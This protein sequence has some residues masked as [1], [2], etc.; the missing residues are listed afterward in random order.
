M[1]DTGDDLPLESWAFISKGGF[2]DQAVFGAGAWAFVEY[3]A[4]V[5]EL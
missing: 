2:E 5:G 4:M 3:P 1:E